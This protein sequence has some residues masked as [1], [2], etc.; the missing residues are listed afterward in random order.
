MQV[1]T[2]NDALQWC[3]WQLK[4]DVWR[5]NVTRKSMSSVH[6]VGSPAVSE[7]AVG[8]GG[9]AVLVGVE[10]IVPERTI[11]VVSVSWCMW[12]STKRQ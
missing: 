11:S 4:L 6:K 5:Q 9:R 12:R 10:E 3:K 7:K 8:L 1:L 2:H